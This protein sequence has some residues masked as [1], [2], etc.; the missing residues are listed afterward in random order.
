MALVEIDVL[1]AQALGLMLDELLLV[2]RVQFPVMQQS[3]RDTWYDLHGRIIFTI[4]KGLVGAGI[5]YHMM[6][7]RQPYDQALSAYLSR[8]TRLRK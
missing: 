7:T 3:E 2:Y 5:D 1:V 4:S 6:N 8:R